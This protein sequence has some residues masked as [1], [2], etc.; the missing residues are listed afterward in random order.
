M[1]KKALII[2]FAGAVVSIISFTLFISWLS[3]GGCPPSYWI[4]TEI[5]SETTYTTT[6]ITRADLPSSSIIRD[7][8]VDLIENT[9]LTRNHSEVSFLDWNAT[10]TILGENNIIPTTNYESF[11]EGYVYFENFLILIQL[12]VMVC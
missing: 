9:T 5:I 6:N 11:W 10:K 8:L 1:F 12:T 7:Q 4:E 3:L 2:I